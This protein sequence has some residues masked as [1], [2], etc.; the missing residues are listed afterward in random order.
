MA[1]KKEAKKKAKEPEERLKV[2]PDEEQ[3]ILPEP[4]PE[5]REEAMEHGE[6]DED[7]DTEEGRKQQVE[8]DEV[9][10]WEAGFA[11]GAAGLGQ[12]GKD[13]LTGEPLMDAD[14]VVEAEI[15]GKLYR[16]ANEENAEKFRE[17][18]KKEKLKGKDN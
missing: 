15:D 1:T 17:K 4:T 6:I 12:L 7:L 11:E 16:F 3:G 13:A 8:E 18:K 9:E 14:D 5:E 10:P 2:Y